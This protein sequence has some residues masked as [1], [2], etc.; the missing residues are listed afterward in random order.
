M[1]MMMMSFFSFLDGSVDGMEHS[2]LYWPAWEWNVWK[3]G[4]SEKGDFREQV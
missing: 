1:P 2:A 4:I 3:M